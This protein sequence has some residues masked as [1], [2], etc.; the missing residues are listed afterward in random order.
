MSFCFDI[1][2]LKNCMMNF[3]EKSYLLL[4]DIIFVF[5]DMNYLLSQT[6]QRLIFKNLMLMSMFCFIQS[7]FIDQSFFLFI[8]NIQILT[9]QTSFLSTYKY[10]HCLYQLQNIS[11]NCTETKAGPENLIITRYVN[12]DKKF[13]A[14]FINKITSFFI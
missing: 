4:F 7:S 9:S 5:S 14:Y 10:C 3:V 13:I 2:D 11:C 6:D 12:T 1:S 8:L